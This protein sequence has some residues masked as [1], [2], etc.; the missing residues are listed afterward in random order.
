MAKRGHGKKGKK[1]KKGS[2]QS[3][4]HAGIAKGMGGGKRRSNKRPLAFLKKMAAK[5]EKNLPRLKAIIAKGGSDGR[6]LT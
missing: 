5:M 3:A 4:M 2:L 6:P 1:G